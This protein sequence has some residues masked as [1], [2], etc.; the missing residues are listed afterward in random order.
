MTNANVVNFPKFF[1]P[2]E[3][4]EII[5]LGESSALQPGVF[6]PRG[7]VVSE[8]RQVKTRDVP[9]SENGWAE[10][11]RRIE[12]LIRHVNAETWKYD[13]TFFEESFQFCRY[14]EGDHYQFWHIDAGRES[15]RR[16]ITA[17][18][19]LSPPTAYSGGRWE[20]CPPCGCGDLVDQGSGIVFPATRAHRVTPVTAGVRYSL[21]CFMSGPP[22]R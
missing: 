14:D 21:V 10:Y 9:A 17:I 18:F 1:T 12:Q 5:E 8:Y 4:E 16:K 13:L 11:A 6:A 3:C 19:Q 20:F 7:E 15:A 22:L 2:E